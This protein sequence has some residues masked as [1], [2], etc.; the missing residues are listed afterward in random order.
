MYVFLTDAFA[1]FLFSLVD[2]PDYFHFGGFEHPI[3][4]Q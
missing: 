3:L 1:I 4:P 2:S